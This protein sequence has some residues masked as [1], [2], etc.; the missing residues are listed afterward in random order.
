MA[1]LYVIASWLLLQV[2]DVL[3]SLLTVPDWTG[4]LVVLLLILGFFPAMIFSWVY[5]MTPEGLKK[6]KDIDRSRSITSETGHKINILIIVMLALAI[7]AV[8]VDRLMPE[9]E[10]VAETPVVE[11]AEETDQA[12]PAQLAA[13]KFAPAPDRSIAVLPFVNMSDDAGNEFFS[14]GI[15]EELLNLLAKI[16]ELQV[17]SRSSAFA[18]KG[19]KIDI[20]EVA[21]KLN[22]AHILE[23]SVRK[24]GNQVRITAQLIEARSDTHI[25]SET[26]D[27][28]LDNIFAIQDEIAAEVVAQLKV[29]LLG[30]T[31]KVT[32]TNPETYALALQA[33]HLYRQGTV[34]SWKHA[35]ELYQQALTIAPNYAPA[36]AGLANIYSGLASQGEWPMEEGY[37]LARQAANKALALDPGYAPVHDSL[38]QLASTVDRDL[39]AAAAHY[40]RA[41]ALDPGNSDIL[42]N[43]A[44]LAR[45]L[46]RPEQ[47]TALLEYAI[48]RDPVNATHH[49]YLG[50]CYVY[51]GH[52]DSAVAS[53]RTALALSPGRVGLQA[54][55]GM[56]L[57]L[58]GK[59]EEAL[60]A[61]QQEHSIWR[62]VYL[63]TAY[64]ALGQTAESDAALNELIDTY[65][66]E[67]AYNIAYVFAYRGEADQAFEWLDKAVVYNDPGLTDIAME[68]M[69]ANIHGDPRWL[70]FLDSIGRSPEQLAAIEFEVTLP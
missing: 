8:V 57:L 35:I 56:T 70:A 44:V 58:E 1:V 59:L 24:A 34:E 5:E 55:L 43:A 69:F 37:A 42:G 20:P 4:S 31:P 10:R 60:A 13:A 45:S 39:A 12:D 28:T 41:L 3:S 16:P 14:D 15:S 19:E 29:T 27:R 32:E 66:R 50:V 64:H 51:A 23:G 52:L 17:T 63:P 21:Q 46:G 30:E 48:D 49:Y 26:Y 54:N 61:I 33:K 62:L 7:G 38:G 36:W 9:A 11:G 65:E 25:W 47:A 6:E 2:T 40:E 53:L 68:P 18:F 22:V 67:A